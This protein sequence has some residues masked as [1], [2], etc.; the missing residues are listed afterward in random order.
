MPVITITRIISTSV[1]PFEM[2]GARYKAQE[3]L[4]P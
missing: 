1:K 3:D 4:E 2:Q